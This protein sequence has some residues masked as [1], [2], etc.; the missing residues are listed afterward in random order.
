MYKIIITTIKGWILHPFSW[1]KWVDIQTFSFLG[2]AFLLQA[3]INKV[4]NLKRFRVQR[5]R[6]DRLSATNVGAINIEEL[7]KRDLIS[8]DVEYFKL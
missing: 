6:Q 8:Y 3:K 1:S 2:E 7:E 4:S 5:T